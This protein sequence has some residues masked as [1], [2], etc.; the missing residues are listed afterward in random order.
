MKAG[1]FRE[2]LMKNGILVIEQFR[3]YKAYETSNKL[4]FDRF[5]RFPGVPFDQ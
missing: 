4:D 5:D 3:M 2:I 1:N